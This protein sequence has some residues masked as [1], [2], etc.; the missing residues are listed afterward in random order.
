MLLGGL[1]HGANLRFIIWGALH[2]LALAVHKTFMDFFPAKKEDEKK[3]FFGSTANVIFVIITFHFVAFC[4]IFFR[5]KDFDIALTVMNNIAELQFDWH[6][7]QTIIEGYRNVFLL[8]AIGFVWHFF[9]QNM[10]DQLKNFFGSMPILFKAV[11]VALTFWV[12]YA[13]ASSGA[14][15]FI[16]FQF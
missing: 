4:W 7:W 13:T 1:W 5:A 14:Q 12:V 11:I 2:G 9:P 3:G 15:P 8:M 10:N 6:K 16:Y